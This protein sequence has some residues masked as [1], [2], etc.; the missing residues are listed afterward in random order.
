M[1]DEIQP[2]AQELRRHVVV[3]GHIVD[4]QRHVA[5]AVVNEQIRAGAPAGDGGAVVQIQP[6]VR[7]VL[8]HGLGKGVLSQHRDHSG[9]FTQQAQIVG[10]VA[11]HA[12][13]GRGHAA[14]IGIPRHQPVGAD[15]ADVHVHAAHHHDVLLLP[16][17]V[18]PP[19]DVALLHQ[20]G[21]M[22]GGAGTGDAR[23]L[24]Q[25]LLGDQ[26]VLPYPLQYLSLT[27]CHPA[28]LLNVSL[29][30]IYCLL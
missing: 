24:R 5:V 29:V 21:D 28:R 12:A 14:R 20:V 27:L 23:L 4:G 9:L 16:E 6:D 11:A 13:Q 8:L 1:V 25:L 15:R 19:G 7:R 26:R 17:Q 18:A 2:L 30:L 3:D 22:H 10:D